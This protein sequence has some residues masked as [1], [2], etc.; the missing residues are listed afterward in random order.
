LTTTNIEFIKESLPFSLPKFNDDILNMSFLLSIFDNIVGPKVVHHWRTSFA[1]SSTK[2]ETNAQL[3]SADLLKYVAIHTLNGE[4]YQDK[5]ANQQKFR[6]YLIKEVECAVFSVFFDASTMETSS[7]SNSDKFD[8]QSA[9][10][11]LGKSSKYARK[12]SS[13]IATNV[14]T[15]LN[16]FSVIVPLDKQEILLNTYGTNTAFFLNMFENLVLEYKVYAHVMPKVS[17]IT[18][19]IDFLAQSIRNLCSQM[20]ILHNRGLCRVVQSTGDIKEI[21]VNETFLNDSLI[22]ASHASINSEFLTSAITSHLITNCY[23]IVIGKMSS[24]VNKMIN[25]LSLFMPSEKRR[26]SCYALEEVS[27]LSPYFYLQGH[28]TVCL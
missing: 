20:L 28:V 3:N 18:E 1:S 17:N 4:L 10:S 25:T 26:L 11:N 14:Q 21:H 13:N 12:G 27:M 9:R 22:T 23:S 6:L 19:A 15:T 24:S 2:S 8:S 7:Y 5:L 16:C